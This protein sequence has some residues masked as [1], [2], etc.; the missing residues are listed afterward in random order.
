M[1]NKNIILKIFVIFCLT[2]FSCT[3]SQ[4]TN[5]FKNHKL[6]RF[7]TKTKANSLYDIIDHFD[8]Y[9]KDNY[10]E[11]S[12][13]E[14]RL[15]RFTNDLLKSYEYYSY[16]VNNYN[17]NVLF[18]DQ[19]VLN[20][21]SSFCPYIKKLEETKLLDDILTK[22][23]N[24]L[25]RSDEVNNWVN[26]IFLKEGIEISDKEHYPNEIIK[27]D[28]IEEIKSRRNHRVEYTFNCKSEYYYSIY[29]SSK[30]SDSIVRK[31]IE[32]IV[33]S[34]CITFTPDTYLRK[35]LKSIPKKGFDN[36]LLK[37]II[38]TDFYLPLL[39]TES[40]CE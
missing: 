7:L 4:K 28:S 25:Y 16:N 6:E 10:S 20:N 15:Y 3:N 24:K 2:F 27:I 31:Y 21:I 8:R 37:S 26:L 39:L 38:F 5:N 34:D 11:V 30:S 9:L 1:I 22:D 17:H 12:S 40:N 32:H 14:E 23:I 29:K 13:S 36:P 33:S 18:K 19:K 35:F